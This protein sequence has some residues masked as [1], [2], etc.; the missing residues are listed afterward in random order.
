MFIIDL[1][2]GLVLTNL[3]LLKLELLDQNRNK[4]ISALSRL[5]PTLELI[6][7][8]DDKTPEVL[9]VWTPCM[10]RVKNFNLKVTKDC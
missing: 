2:V 1:G 9:N 4:S 5:S 3:C 8:P 7:S 6:D 10:L